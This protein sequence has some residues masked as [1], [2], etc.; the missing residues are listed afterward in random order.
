MSKD[1]YLANW[2]VEERCFLLNVGMPS[3][4]SPP[5]CT[6]SSFPPMFNSSKPFV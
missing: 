2:S 5:Y 6:V 1:K 3:R 4:Y